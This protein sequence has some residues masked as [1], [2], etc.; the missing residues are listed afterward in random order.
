VVTTNFVPSFGNGTIR[1]RGNGGEFKAARGRGC[2]TIDHLAAKASHPVASANTIKTAF[3]LGLMFD[4]ART[5]KTMLWQSY[6]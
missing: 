5:V 2:G 1:K 6:P 4:Y 3:G